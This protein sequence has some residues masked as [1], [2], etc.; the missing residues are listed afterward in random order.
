[1]RFSVV[2]G[3]LLCAA[4]SYVNAA[5]LFGLS[6][7]EPP[8]ANKPIPG[9]SPLLQCDVDQSQS[10]DVTQVNLVPNPPQRGENLTIAAAGVLQTTIEEGAYIDIEVRLGY[11]KLIS[12]TYDLC[13]Q[14]EEND[15]DGLKCPIE[16]G[17]YELNKIVEIPSEVPPGK[18]SVIARAYNVDDEQITCLTGEVIFPAY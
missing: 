12:Q 5:S 8:S 15:I 18:Y 6:F 11:I 1:M 16:E 17:V 2:T 9:D 3:Y 7:P 14:L 10:L 13:E 4:A